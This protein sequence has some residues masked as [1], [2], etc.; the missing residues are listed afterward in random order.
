[1]TLITTGRINT[2]QLAHLK[3]SG[4]AKSGIATDAMG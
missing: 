4:I 3:T 2:A 1:M